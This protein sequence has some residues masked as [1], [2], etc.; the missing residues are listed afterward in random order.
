MA[1]R[2]RSELVYVIYSQ[3]VKQID[4]KTSEL[5]TASVITLYLMRNIAERDHSVAW[6]ILFVAIV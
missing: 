1:G 2:E 3:I 5:G 4:R 6:V